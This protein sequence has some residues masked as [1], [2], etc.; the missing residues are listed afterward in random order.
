MIDEKKGEKALITEL[1]GMRQRI[2]GLEKLNVEHNRVEEALRESQQLLRLVLDAIPVR[3]FWKDREFNYLGCNHAFAKDAGLESPEE[4]IGKSDFDLVWKEQVEIYRSDDRMVIESGV[5]KL[6]YEEPRTTP[7]GGLIWLRTSKIPLLDAAGKI[8][9]VLGTYE[10][11][12]ERKQA[13]EALR[14]SQRHF[15][16]IIDFLPDATF[17]IDKEGKII[18]WNRAIEEMTG[19][20]AEEMLGKGDR[21]DAIP[22]YGERRPI[23]IDL[24]SM[25]SEVLKTKYASIRREKDVLMGDADCPM[26]R[27]G[28]RFLSG[29]ATLIYNLKGEIV[30]AI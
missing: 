5:P 6:N 2:V 3:I 15:S 28:R 29:W 20:Q 14:E 26:L 4:I 1:V 9:G 18:A 13:E 21:E 19:F 10:D 7:E 30:G 11:I 23:L 24:L 25:Q 22:F 17:V 27:G 12:T 8:K 16:D